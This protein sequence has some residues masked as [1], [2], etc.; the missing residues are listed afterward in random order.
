MY[1]WL[2]EVVVGVAGPGVVVGE[3][4]G[5]FLVDHQSYDKVHKCFYTCIFLP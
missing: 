3:G 4:R 5:D 1:V 2:Q